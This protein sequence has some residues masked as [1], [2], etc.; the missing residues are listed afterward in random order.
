VDVKKAL[1]AVA[2]DEAAAIEL[3]RKNGQQKAMKKSERSTGEG[4]VVSYIHSNGKMGAIVKVFCES[5]FV[6][7]NEEFKAL[8]TDI[9]MHITAMNPIYL[10]PEDVTAEIVSKEREIWKE[11]LLQEG[12]AE[13]MLEKILAGKEK[14]FREEISLLTQPFVKNP[15]QTVGELI[16]Q[17]IAKIGENIRVGEFFRIEL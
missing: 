14:K 11:Q 17:K 9:A 6:A 7:R 13:E 12:K 15:E 16:A 1:D 3:L 2:G 10:N 4:I 5:D 8:A